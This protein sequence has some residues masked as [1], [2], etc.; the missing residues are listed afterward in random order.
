MCSALSVGNWGAKKGEK[1]NINDI[2]M[3]LDLGGVRTTP[4]VTGQYGA[5]YAV[6]IEPTTFHKT[7]QLRA[8]DAKRTIAML[9][10]GP[11]RRSATTAEAAVRHG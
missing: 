11:K 10:Y 4:I 7:V 3:I 6:G 8:E 1:K 5:A 9:G 2:G